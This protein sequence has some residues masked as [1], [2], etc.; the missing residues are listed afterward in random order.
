MNNHCLFLLITFCLKVFLSVQ[1]IFFEILLC[2]LSDF[3]S[4]EM[5]QTLHSLTFFCVVS[6]LSIL[7][8]YF[9]VER[10]SGKLHLAVDSFLN[11]QRF[12]LNQ[13]LFKIKIRIFSFK[14]WQELIF[15]ICRGKLNSNKVDYWGHIQERVGG[16]YN[17]RK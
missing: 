16:R 10:K 6:A 15:A 11:Y 14:F 2:A 7:E 1:Q 3:R 8:L 9:A 13:I 17:N 4:M 5:S 12:W